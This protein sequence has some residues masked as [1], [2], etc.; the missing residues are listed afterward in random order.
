MNV[1]EIRKALV[2]LDANMEVVDTYYNRVSSLAVKSARRIGPYYWADLAEEP[3]ESYE[4][5]TK[6]AV[7]S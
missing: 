2:G 6:V 5:T 1:K 7:I 4:T 3:A